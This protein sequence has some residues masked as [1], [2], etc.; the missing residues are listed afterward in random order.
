MI[1][2]NRPLHIFKFLWGS[3]DEQHPVTINEIAEHLE[4]VGIHAG[5]KTIAADLEDLQNCGFDVVKVRSRSNRY[6]VGNRSMELAELKMIVDAVQAAKFISRTKSLAL[7]EKLTGLASPHQAAQLRRNLY[8]EGKV[9]T[10]NEAVCYAVDLLNQSINEQTTVE[11]QYIEYTDNKEK[12]LKHNGQL[13]ALSPYDLVWS[14]DNYYVLGWSE[15]HKKIATFRVDRMVSV[16]PSMVYFHDRPADYDIEQSCK[17][18]F[19]MYDGERCTVR[20]LCESGMMNT[21]ID[22]F[23]ED[24][25]IEQT[26]DG[27]FI[28]EAEISVG[29]T[30]YSWV[31]NYSGRPRILS[32]ERLRIEYQ[33]RLKAALN[34]AA[35]K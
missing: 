6:F 18:L 11:F 16:K 15:R 5:R 21:I 25:K 9:K 14:N 22:R 33:D 35:L 24:V 30:F 28:A 23:S 17:Q 13:Y 4:S 29:P 19:L 20:L 2:K 26:E 32:P 7:I 10:A 3:T 12:V 8:V 27:H 34:T 1:E 31:Y